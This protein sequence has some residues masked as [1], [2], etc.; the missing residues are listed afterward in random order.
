MLSNI[1]EGFSQSTDRAFARH[2]YIARGST[3]E[4]RSQLVILLDRG[5][6]SGDDFRRIEQSAEE[7]AKMLTGLIKHLLRENRKRRG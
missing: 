1:A 6:V 7:I 3:A 4:V 5:V 2:L